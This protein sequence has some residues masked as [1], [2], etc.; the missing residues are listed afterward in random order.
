M[1]SVK[2]I[3]TYRTHTN[4]VYIGRPSIWGNPFVLISEVDRKAVL[5]NYKEWIFHPN[6]K[7]LRNKARQELKGKILLCFCNPKLCHGDVLAAIAD[8]PME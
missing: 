6:R 2:N 8:S 7:Q 1:T 4:T 5:E 3:R